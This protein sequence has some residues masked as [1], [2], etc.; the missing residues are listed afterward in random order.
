MKN[1]ELIRNVTD[2]LLLVCD[3]A[4][5]KD[6]SGFNKPDSDAV[7]KSYPDMITIAPL[8]LKYKNQIIYMGFDY[9]KLKIAVLEV[10]KDYTTNWKDHVVGFGKHSKS[11]YADMA[12]NERGYLSWMVQNFDQHDDRWMAANA[13]LSNLP[14]PD[15]NDNKQK[16]TANEEKPKVHIRITKDKKNI[17]IK[18]HFAAKD[19]CRSLSQ[20][21]WVNDVWISPISIIDEVYNAFNVVSDSFDLTYSSSFKDAFVLHNETVKKSDK[22]SSELEIVNFDLFIN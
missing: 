16:R 11:T 20:R 15:S 9:D 2:S 21:R 22:A 5:S 12:E 3:G 10:Q 18:S 19:V 13:V 14:I 7:R 6:E 1:I 8:L 4:R 17:S